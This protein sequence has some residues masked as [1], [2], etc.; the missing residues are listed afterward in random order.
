MAPSSY[1]VNETVECKI[2]P[3]KQLR[4]AEMITEVTGSNALANRLAPSDSAGHDWYRFVLSYPPHLV[5][6]Y[7][8]RFGATERS[9]VLDPFFGTGTTLVECKKRR[10]PSIGLEAHPMTHFAS[11]V[12]TQWAIDRDALL[13]H[14]RMAAELARAE[15]EGQRVGVGP[16]AAAMSISNEQSII[17]PEEAQK[18]LLA[19]SISPRP[20]HRVL[21]LL[22]TLGHCRNDVFHPYERL[23]LAKA[24]VYSIGNL[25][26]PAFWSRSRSW[27]GKA[28]RACDRSLVSERR[29][30]GS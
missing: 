6:T 8:D 4:M 2:Y 28:G 22:Q 10:V 14:A 27:P 15:L 3:M 30:D 18:L 12:K 19:G 17:L 21:V 25:W 7:L 24:L 26:K 23:A 20:L 16:D 1:H 13:R 5:R 9:L 11:S 29:I